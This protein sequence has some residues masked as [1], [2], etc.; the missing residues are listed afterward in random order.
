MSYTQLPGILC[1][2]GCTGCSGNSRWRRLHLSMRTHHDGPGP[3]LPCSATKVLC[4]LPLTTANVQGL[5]LHS[6]IGT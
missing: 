3:M 5:A 4:M 1:T 6:S 2:Q